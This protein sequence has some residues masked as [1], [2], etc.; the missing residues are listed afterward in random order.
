[1]GRNPAAGR[2]AWLLR[3]AGRMG[4]LLA[5]IVLLA[6][7]V[8]P[9]PD[10][11]GTRMQDTIWWWLHFPAW[12]LVVVSLQR[13]IGPV[14]RVPLV[15]AV[16]VGVLLLEALQAITGRNPAWQDVWM[17]WLGAG[18]G[19]LWPFRSRLRYGIAIVAL[20]LISS[21]PIVAAWYDIRQQH[22]EFPLLASA[23]SIGQTDRWRA[24]GV[25]LERIGNVGQSGQAAWR[26][27]IDGEH[28]YPGFFMSEMPGDWAG[29]RQLQL[30]VVVPGSDS[31]K[32]YFRLMDRAD[33]TYPDRYQTPLVMPPGAQQITVLLD[34]E[35]KTPS[36]RPL[37]LS[38]VFE[39]GVFFEAQHAG[40][41]LYLHRAKLVR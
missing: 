40:S 9:L 8:V 16:L 6:L 32:G 3:R 23:A 17:G 37:D 2:L 1:M 10:R 28:P 13:L 35:L 7:L 12:F 31:L 38:R 33:V 4:P 27:T 34:Q 39:W 26:V 22:R 11:T 29:Y 21:F 41:T 5:L 19:L 24:S 25:R 15:L 18:C 20:S 30:D 36:G 14:R